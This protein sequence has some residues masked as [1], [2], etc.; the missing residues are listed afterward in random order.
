MDQVADTCLPDDEPLKRIAD[1]I[2]RGMVV[3]IDVDGRVVAASSAALERL[4]GGLNSL[5]LAPHSTTKNCTVSIVH[6]GTDGERT[7]ICLIKEAKPDSGRDLIAAVEGI[8]SD[9][10]WLARALIEK[11][12]AW[13]QSRGSV[14]NVSDLEKLTMREREILALICE[15]RS[16]ADMSRLLGLSQNTVRNH[17]AS[18]YRKIG[19]NRRSAAIIWARERAVTAQD[20]LTLKPAR[21]SRPAHEQNGRH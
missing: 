5:H 12:N 2:A 17:V 15:G 4:N 7:S 20:V 8:M 3:V 18:L 21:R 1:A 14:A 19:V 9:T 10:S 6:V 16:D 13:R 11:L